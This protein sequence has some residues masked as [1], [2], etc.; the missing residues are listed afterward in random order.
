[1][2][3]NI[4]FHDWADSCCD[5]TLKRYVMMSNLCSLFWKVE[6]LKKKKKKCVDHLLSWPNR[7]PGGTR[8]GI[9][10]KSHS[11]LYSECANNFVQRNVAKAPNDTRVS[12]PRFMF[13]GWSLLTKDKRMQAL[14]SDQT[15]Q[16]FPADVSK[17]WVPRS[18]MAWLTCPSRHTFS[19]LFNYTIHT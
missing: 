11:A 16:V 3:W 17:G 2:F 7:R 12:V 1:M 8:R 4:L 13:C 5:V 10:P 19:Y 15:E 14:F 6:I 18:F 9:L